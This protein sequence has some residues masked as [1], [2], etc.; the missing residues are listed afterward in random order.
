MIKLFFRLFGGFFGK[1]I[2]T[3]KLADKFPVSVKGL[4]RENNKILMLLNER[5]QWDL[6]G[7]KLE[8]NC[9]IDTILESEVKDE[10]NLSVKIGRLIYLKKN[11][12]YRTEVVVA[13]YEVENISEDPVYIS[14][15]HFNY[16]YFDPHE[17]EK[18]NVPEWVTAVI[19]S[20]KN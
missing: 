7:G 5:G 18:L 15:E 1:L 16:N 2:D 9:D 10:T 6:P 19:K 14:H 20:Y 8:K 4:L 17:I 12:V 3:D 13:I 11:I